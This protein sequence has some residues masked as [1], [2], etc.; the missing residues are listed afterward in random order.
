MSGVSERAQA[1]AKDGSLQN[2]GK[3]TSGPQCSVQQQIRAG[4]V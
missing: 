2:R 4:K 3:G 1:E